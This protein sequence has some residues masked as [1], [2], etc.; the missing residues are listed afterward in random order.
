MP[1]SINQA[2]YWNVP[3]IVIAIALRVEIGAQPWCFLEQELALGISVPIIPVENI[4]LGR[5]DR[6]DPRLIWIE[7]DDQNKPN[8]TAIDSSTDFRIVIRGGVEGS[9]DEQLVRHDGYCTAIENLLYRLENNPLNSD[10]TNKLLGTWPIALQQV[11]TDP[12]EPE[13]EEN[14]LIPLPL[15]AYERANIHKQIGSIKIVSTSR[16]PST[17]SGSALS[18]FEGGV[19]VKYSISGNVRLK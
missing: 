18:G 14:P 9:V 12:E 17:K 1:L 8:N 19:S 13:S 5:N 6:R 3:R 16:F 10:G 2:L 15:E 11:L 7:Y 4:Y